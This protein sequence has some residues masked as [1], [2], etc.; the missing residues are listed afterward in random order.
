[1]IFEG[2][3]NLRFTLSREVYANRKKVREVFRVL[4]RIYIYSCWSLIEMIW[5]EKGVITCRVW[6]FYHL[7]SHLN[8]LSCV[9][10]YIY[11]QNCSFVFTIVVLYEIFCDYFLYW[12]HTLIWCNVA[13]L[14]S[15]PLL[16]KNKPRLY[17]NVIL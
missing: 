16:Y 8:F 2:N 13:H 4:R 6:L 7:F 9:C 15:Q 5:I 17:T 10:I 1:M 3:R 14:Y 12:F 11:S